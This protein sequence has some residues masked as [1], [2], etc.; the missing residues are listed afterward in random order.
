MLVMRRRGAP[1]GR[2]PF[3]EGLRGLAALYVV[4]G[5]IATLADPARL[6]GVTDRAPS[7]LQA[8]MR[9]LGFGHFAVAAFIVLSGFCLQL[10]LFSRVDAKVGSLSNFFKRRALRILPAYY[11]CLA[12]SIGVC[13][14]VTSHQPGL[15]RFLPVTTPN[16][17]AH[18]FL[19][20]NLSEDWMY[21]IN[22]VLW[23][24]AIEAQLYLLFPLLVAAIARFGRLTTLMGAAA[25][26]CLAVAFLPHAPKLY[27]W[28]LGLFV[29]GMVAAHLA[30]RPNLRSGTRPLVG[31]MVCVPTAFVACWLAAT[32][33]PLPL[34]DAFG[35]VAVAA[36]C[37][38]LTTTPKGLVVSAFSARP[39]V[40]LGGFSYSL[41][42]MHHPLLQVV[43]ALRPA[44]WTGEVAT[45]WYLL[46]VGLPLA[47]VATW[48]FSLLFE[49][50][51]MPRRMAIAEATELIPLSLP[52]RTC[53]RASAKAKPALRSTVRPAPELS[54][55][56]DAA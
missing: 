24:I 53:A 28:Y 12:I 22:G 45:F 44:A 8:L 40:A 48:G 5:H 47:L 41:Y 30:Y 34:G 52:L 25:V 18:V 11:A 51:F 2:L 23:S 9:P 6:N 35:G 27:P 14:G 26:S 32:S 33:D 4:L 46:L 7:W 36:L 50:P 39:V 42:L 17:L 15:E 21:K 37:Y 54:P 29:V 1:G 43:Y 10:S 19:I 49:R 38:A 56:T 31:W 55:A 13:L 20:H 3:L 16:V